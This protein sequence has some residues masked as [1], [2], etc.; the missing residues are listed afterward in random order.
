MSHLIPVLKAT[1]PLM[2]VCKRYTLDQLI[3]A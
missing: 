1:S 2:K 3:G